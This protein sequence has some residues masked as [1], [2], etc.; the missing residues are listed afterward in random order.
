MVR[1]TLPGGSKNTTEGVKVSRMTLQSRGEGCDSS[2]PR[3]QPSHEAWS[4]AFLPTP[5]TRGQRVGDLRKR[6]MTGDRA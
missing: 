1:V 4:G 5:G 2:K 3:E 6:H